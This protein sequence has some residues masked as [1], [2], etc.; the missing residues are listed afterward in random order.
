[1]GVPNYSSAVLHTAGPLVDLCIA[2]DP[3]EAGYI[4]RE[5]FPLKPVAF[6][7]DYI[8]AIDTASMLRLIDGDMSTNTLAP[9]VSFQIGANQQYTCVPYA[10]RSPVSAYDVANADAALQFQMRATKYCMQ[11]MDQRME[12]AAVV[13]KLINT[14]VMTSYETLTAAE[15]W[16]NYGSTSSDPIVDLQAAVAQVR[17]KVGKPKA[18]VKVA[19]HQ[20][21]WNAIRNHPSVLQRVVYSGG[22]GAVLTK[23]VFAGMIDLNSAD[24]LVI[25]V[26]KYTSSKEGETTATYASFIGANAIVAYVDDGGLDDFCLGHEFAFNGMNGEAP[27][28]VRQYRVEE[29]GISGTDYVQVGTSI[30]FKATNASNAGFL[31]TAVVD[32]SNTEMYPDL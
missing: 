22:A 1:M 17:V 19:I 25:T 6:A 18:R 23:E 5:F 16:D 7:T 2:Y 26:A 10:F 12:Y 9:T 8:R 15:R 3:S 28:F 29:Q 31:F 24:D 13:S 14:S 21:V 11:M 27:Y 32:T 30:D 4:R 20:Y